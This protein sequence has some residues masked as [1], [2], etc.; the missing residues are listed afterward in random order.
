MLNLRQEAVLNSTEIETH[1]LRWLGE[2]NTP[3][4]I[5]IT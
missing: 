5:V 2:K 1:P 4:A 3:T